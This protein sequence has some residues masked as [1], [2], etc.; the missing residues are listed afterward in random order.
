MGAWKGLACRPN[1]IATSIV[2]GI[3]PP[4]G[5][6]SCYS[7][8][9]TDTGENLL[10]KIRVLGKKAE[11]GK[12]PAETRRRQRGCGPQSRGDPTTLFCG[13]TLEYSQAK[14]ARANIE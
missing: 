10:L 1:S 5:I 13:S 3:L 8:I 7:A 9:N 12:E 6:L 4:G 14:R 11:N 2:A